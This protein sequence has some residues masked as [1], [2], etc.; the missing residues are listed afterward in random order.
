VSDVSL[1]GAW[2]L[3]SF[4]FTDQDGGTY[5]P[6]GETPKGA[7][8]IT[9]DG[10]LSL[11]F[12]AADRSP[13]RDDHVL[14]GNEAERTAAATSYVSFGGPCRIEGDEVVVEVEH[15]FH[16]NWAG[17][18]QRRKFVLDGDRLTLSTTKTL[19]VGGRELMGQAVLRR[20]VT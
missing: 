1:V 3:E 8:L 7:V 18:A 6:L 19:T 9:P 2:R 20:A 5:F 4:V 16:P 17:G 10:H 12:M 13:Y 11:S 14:G 15:A